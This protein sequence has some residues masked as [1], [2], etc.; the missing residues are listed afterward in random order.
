MPVFY[1]TKLLVA[2]GIALGVVWSNTK[3]LCGP[4]LAL[5]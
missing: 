2:L 1:L 5:L 4:N 3:L